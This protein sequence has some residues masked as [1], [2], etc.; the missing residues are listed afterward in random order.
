MRVAGLWRYPVK[1]L[2]GEPCEA[3]EVLDSGLAGDR[4]YG[5]EELASGTVLSAK[6]EGRLLSGYARLDGV[7]PHV[8]LPS[9]AELRP[10]PA[11]DSA[12]SEW[13]GRSCR[14]VSAE[15]HGPGTFEGTTDFE[16]DAA[17]LRRW[18]G[19]AERFVDT[20]PVHLLTT[21][22]LAAC[23]GERPDLEWSP[24]RFR[25]NVLLDVDGDTLIE[26]TWVGRHLRLGDVE[27]RIEKPCS[28]CVMTTRSQ[29]DGLERQLDVLRY[30][31]ATQESH[32]GV[33]AT[34]VRPGTLR[35]GDLAEVRD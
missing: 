6:R 23:A 21:A 8:R 17:E 28:R 2:Q 29:P 13:L 24:R 19:P 33:L 31:N 20:L 30:V 7:I 25:P 22:S 14:L 27:L 18:Q 16:R 9:G 11:L 12:L 15:E 4:S 3:V 5:I 10:G 26:Q 35:A 34:V 1:S 32:L